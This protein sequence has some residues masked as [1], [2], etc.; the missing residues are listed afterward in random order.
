MKRRNFLSSFAA[1]V[2]A[3]FVGKALGESPLKQA[4]PTIS[5]INYRG[6]ST[7]HN[8]IEYEPYRITD[9]HLKVSDEYLDAFGY[10]DSHVLTPNQIRAFEDADK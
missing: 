10:Y 6:I 7:F 1:L 9:P 5:K 3:P 4:S 2:A 8:S